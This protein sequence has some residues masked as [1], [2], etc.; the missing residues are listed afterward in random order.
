M[1]PQEKHRR[2]ELIGKIAIVCSGIVC[3]GA[4]FILLMLHYR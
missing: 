1:T 2:A 3:A 4:L